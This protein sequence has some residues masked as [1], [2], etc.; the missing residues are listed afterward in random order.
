[1]VYTPPNISELA[2][3][4]DNSYTPPNI[5]ALSIVM[6][7]NNGEPSKVEASLDQVYHIFEDSLRVALE[8]VYHLLYVSSAALEQLYGLRESASLIQNYT[9]MRVRESSLIQYYSS[10]SF[11]NSIFSS[12]YKDA[13][14]L[15]ASVDQTW[16]VSEPL[17]SAIDEYY[18]ITG[19][20]VRE[21]LDQTWAIKLND[22]VIN[23]LCQLYTFAGGLEETTIESPT[24]ETGDSEALAFSSITVEGSLDSYCLSADISTKSYAEYKRVYP[25]TDVTFQIQGVTFEMF[26]E[27]K[28]RSRNTTSSIQY[29]FQC[30]SKSALLDSPYASPIYGDLGGKWAS[31]IAEA[32]IGDLGITFVWDTAD[33]FYP[34]NHIFGNG[35]TPLT[36]LKRLASPT[37]SILQTAPDGTLSIR[38]YYNVSPTDWKTSSPVAHVSDASDFFSSDEF[39]D[40]RLGYNK[41]LISNLLTSNS[42]PK[43]ILESEEISPTERY[44]KF[45]QVPWIDGTDVPFRTSGGENVSIITTPEWVAGITF[46]LTELVE[47]V[48]GT[49]SVS[50][51]V[52]EILNFSYGDADHLGAISFAE[53]GTIETDISSHSLVTITYLTKYRQ[54]KATDSRIESVQFILGD[55]ES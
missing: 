23:T 52:Y 50:K 40:L 43:E 38:P 25:L 1:M 44:I 18:S 20:L 26:V 3:V 30:L 12:K 27:S 48:S 29:S 28:S 55:E 33:Q 9:N 22:G 49:G 21:G 35:D 31:E 51:P 41:F 15:R 34:L 6:P 46:P 42:A 19:N 4:L 7:T 14:S 47:I 5:G 13:L 16:F 32:L 37:K 54:W 53:D 11:V 8:Q 10:T 24:V 2:F 36:I 39:L 45:Y 17:S